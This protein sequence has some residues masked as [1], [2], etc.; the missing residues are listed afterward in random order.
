M[1]HSLLTPFLSHA[2][3]L[4]APFCGRAVGPA[5]VRLTQ[6][7]CTQQIEQIRVPV[8]GV[9]GRADGPAGGRA[10]GTRSTDTGRLHRQRSGA[11]ARA[12]AA[13]AAAGSGSP[14]RGRPWGVAATAAAAAGGGRNR[15][16]GR[17]GSGCCR[18][19]QG[20]QQLWE[21]H[22]ESG[23]VGAQ[24]LLPER[25]VLAMNQRYVQCAAAAFR[26]RVER[27]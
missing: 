6:W 7:R 15:C 24:L 21:E 17:D 23:I 2:V 8:A 9:C 10:G 4:I 22:S 5:R 19:C 3:C 26:A 27:N 14:V 16:G 20:V 1:T 11:G 18:D 12:A 25:S 13:A